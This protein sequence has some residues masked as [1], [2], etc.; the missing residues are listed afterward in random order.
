MQAAI[1]HGDFIEDSGQREQYMGSLRQVEQ[2]TLEQL[3][4]PSTTTKAATDLSKF[5]PAICGF[6]KMLNTQRKGFQDTGNAVHGSALQEVEQ[7]REVAYEVEAIR[8]VQK[9]NHY[10]AHGYPGLHR[11]IVGFM[12]TGRL[13]ADSVAYKPA[14]AA[15]AETALGRKHRIYPVATSSQLYVTTEFTKTIATNSTKTRECDPFQVK[16]LPIPKNPKNWH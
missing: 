10:P 8:E 1:D 6:M 4:G 16:H 15:L 5:S 12:N 11:D 2:Q 9:P 7:E 3:Y 13:A 14:F